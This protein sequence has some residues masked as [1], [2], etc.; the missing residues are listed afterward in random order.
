MTPRD[1][2]VGYICSSCG[3]AFTVMQA[4]DGQ[5]EDITLCWDCVDQLFAAADTV[6]RKPSA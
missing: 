3:N 4:Q 6:T 1:I 2:P 5:D